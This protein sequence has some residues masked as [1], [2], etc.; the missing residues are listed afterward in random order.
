MICLVDAMIANCWLSFDAA[1]KFAKGEVVLIH[2]YNTRS[3]LTGERKKDEYDKPHPKDHPQAEHVSLTLEFAR[4]S[5]VRSSRAS[6][7]FR[8]GFIE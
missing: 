2:V 1:H 8:R 5:Q 3:Q 7:R 6:W 4:I